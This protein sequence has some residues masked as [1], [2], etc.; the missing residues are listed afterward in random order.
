VGHQRD[1]SHPARAIGFRHSLPA[2]PRPSP[3]GR[4]VSAAARID[5]AWS[6]VL[7]RLGRE[8]IIRKAGEH[9]N[10]SISPIAAESCHCDSTGH[11]GLPNNFA[12]PFANNNPR[13]ASVS[14]VIRHNCPLGESILNADRFKPWPLLR[15]AFLSCQSDQFILAHFFEFWPKPSKDSFEKHGLLKLLLH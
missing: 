1:F 13:V 5:F 2:H 12:A 10:G 8:F 3:L 7:I 11:K 4:G 9:L 14:I 6:L 15:I